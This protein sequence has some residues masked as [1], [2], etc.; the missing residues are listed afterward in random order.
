MSMKKRLW[1]GMTLLAA[2]GCATVGTMRS[3]SAEAGTERRFTANQEAVLS[4]SQ[5]A[6]AE[7][8]LKVVETYKI[9]DSSSAIIAKEGMNAVSYGVLVR[10]VTQKISEN[11]TSVRFLTKRRLATN[12]FAEGDFSQ[13]FFWNLEGKLK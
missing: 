8:G 12:V 1:L 5:E 4:A 6:L 2:C 13:P 9:D 3:N 7:M 10:V 11:E